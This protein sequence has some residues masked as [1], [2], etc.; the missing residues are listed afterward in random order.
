MSYKS[1]PNP[2]LYQTQCGWNLWSS[3]RFTKW[4][5]RDLRNTLTGTADMMLAASD[6]TEET[7]VSWLGKATKPGILKKGAHY[8]LHLTMLYTLRDLRIN[9][10]WRQR[11]SF[12]LIILYLTFSTGPGTTQAFHSI[13]TWYQNGNRTQ[14]K[15]EDGD[16]LLAPPPPDPSTFLPPL[17]APDYH[18]AGT[19]DLST[20]LSPLFS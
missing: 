8:M 11:M 15:H 18:R 9:S 20:S 4:S 2:H 12:L 13:H 19:S 5:K 14:K 1:A 10:L 3:I 17:I 16:S 7:D 6:K